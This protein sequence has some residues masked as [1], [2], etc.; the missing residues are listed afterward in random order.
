MI[1]P[2]EIYKKFL[3]KINKNDINRNI[4]VPKSQFV[5]LFNEQKRKYIEDELKSNESSDY[6]EEFAELLVV[7]EKLQKINED[8][9]KVNFKI[10]SDFIKRVGSYSIASKGD[11]KNEVLINWYYKPKDINVLLTNENYNPSFE[12]RETIA[13]LNKD[14]LSVYKTDFSI[15]DTYFTYYKEPEDLDIEGYVHIDGSN[16][17]DKPINLS[18]ILT[19]FIIDR[20]VVEA[21]RNYESVEQYQLAIQRQQLNEKQ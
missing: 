3:L 18:T 12:Y 16:S 1:S 10:P 9:L 2:Q 13:L 8:S 15:D 20:V 5:L 6:I 14:V 4:K 17:V 19:E 11:C 7:D 21:T